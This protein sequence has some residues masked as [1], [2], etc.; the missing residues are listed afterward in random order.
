MFKKHFKIIKEERV[1]GIL[2]YKILERYTILFFIHWWSTP[3]FAPPHLHQT[4]KEAHDYIKEMCPNAVIE[5][6][7]RDKCV[8]QYGE[9][10][11][12]LYDK[13]CR[14]ESIC[15]ITQTKVF[16][17]AIEKVRGYE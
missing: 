12:E 14:G 4:Y 3:V 11:G 5:T 17:D 8:L 9:H 1:T 10:F 13:S 6:S 16:L 7:L 2:P 15:N